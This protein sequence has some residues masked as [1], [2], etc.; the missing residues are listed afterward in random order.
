MTVMI[1]PSEPVGN[2]P[3]TAKWLELEPCHPAY[4]HRGASAILRG[5]ALPGGKP[6]RRRE[7]ADS[8]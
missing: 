5:R 1:R 7:A 6:G 8:P 3:G 2:W 4:G